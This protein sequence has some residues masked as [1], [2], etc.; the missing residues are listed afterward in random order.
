MKVELIYERGCPGIAEA[1]ESILRAFSETSFPTAWL[2]WDVKS[3]LCPERWNACGSPTVLVDGSDVSKITFADRNCCRLYLGPDGQY[4][5]AP[6]TEMV[7]SALLRSG[8]VR[9]AKFIRGFTVLPSIGLALLPKLACPMCWPAYA[10]FLST[11]GLSFLL[12]AKHLL[13]AIALSLALSVGS[14]VLRARQRHEYKS[15][16]VG[17]AAAFVVLL[18]KFRYDSS[19]AVYGG[20]ATLLAVSIWDGWPRRIVVNSCPQCAP[21]VQLRETECKET[22]V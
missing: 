14:L 16:V 8:G 18:G 11:L 5:R 10:G 7:R 19:A 17:L 9:P 3:P 22:K 6:T 15:A 20:L 21:A 12:S 4:A 13:A 2:E 1:R